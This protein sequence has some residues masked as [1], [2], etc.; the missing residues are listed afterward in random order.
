M[1]AEK[2]DVWRRV[3]P[4]AVK[5]G[6]DWRERGYVTTVSDALVAAEVAGG[7]K[8]CENGR[9]RCVLRLRLPRASAGQLSGERLLLSLPEAAAPHGGGETLR[10]RSRETA[11]EPDR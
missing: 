6:G 2:G 11:R 9:V 8:S 3:E 4:G 5:V 1:G 10:A 7:V